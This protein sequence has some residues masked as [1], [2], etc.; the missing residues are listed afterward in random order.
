MQYRD[1]EQTTSSSN[2]FMLIVDIIKNMENNAV[3]VT[4]N[5]GHIS[6]SEN[7][8]TERDLDAMINDLR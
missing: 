6:V 5:S 8:D 3:V 2:I 7:I 4:R 1:T